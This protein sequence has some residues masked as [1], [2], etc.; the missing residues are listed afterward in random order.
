MLHGLV[1]SQQLLI[2]VTVFLLGQ[3]QFLGEGEE[4]P[5]VAD[6]LLQHGTHGGSGGVCDE[7]CGWV[8]VRQ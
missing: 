5:G 3:V 6:T 2:I 8:G 7:W 4:L 1:G